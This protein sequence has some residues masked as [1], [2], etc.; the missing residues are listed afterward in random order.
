MHDS[1]RLRRKR[2]QPLQSFIRIGG[3]RIGVGEGTIL[4]AN[5]ALL[6]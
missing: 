5:Q 3:I 4:I 6:K 2:R 1:E